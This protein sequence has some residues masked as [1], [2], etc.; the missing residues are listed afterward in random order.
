MTQCPELMSLSSKSGKYFA[1]SG[2]ASSGIYF[3]S[4]P[5]INNEGP[6]HRD[7]FRSYGQLA[8]IPLVMAFPTI[9][10]G[11]LDVTCS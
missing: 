6:V 10:N 8:I 11:T 7:I 3:D 5:L 2:M 4:V 1:I 9:S